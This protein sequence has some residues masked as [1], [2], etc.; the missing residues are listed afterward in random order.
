M[1]RSRQQSARS[2]F[3]FG[4]VEVEPLRTNQQG[5]PEAPQVFL[6]KMKWTEHPPIAERQ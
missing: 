1:S 4:S 6:T 5:P 3:T 2:T